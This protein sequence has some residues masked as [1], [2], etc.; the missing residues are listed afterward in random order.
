M[1]TPLTLEQ[2]QSFVTFVNNAFGK[3]PYTL[4]LP[5]DFTSGKVLVATGFGF[6]VEPVDIATLTA[7]AVK[8]WQ[9]ETD[10][11][12]GTADTPNDL[13]LHND[14]LYVVVQD[15]TS[16]GL[17]SFNERL[18]LARVSLD[19]DLEY[20]E[21]TADA[22]APLTAGQIV[23]R[24]RSIRYFVVRAEYALPND[25]LS[26]PRVYNTAVCNSSITTPT[27]VTIERLESNADYTA[28]A[29]ITFTP[30]TDPY[31]TEGVIAFNDVYMGSAPDNTT[32]LYMPENSVLVMRL[33]TAGAGL[34]WISINLLGEF[35]SYT[36]PNFNVPN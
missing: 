5:A 27:V 9:P 11:F 14:S 28:V 15:F 36:N 16:G 35:I 23:G 26:E 10:Y 1:S 18:G 3:R 32:G 13:V 6:G 8:M 34:E 12:A 19:T 29:T 24:Y 2:M 20:L 30:N 25:N 21:I 17:G 22:S 31:F 33:T 7:A 4:S